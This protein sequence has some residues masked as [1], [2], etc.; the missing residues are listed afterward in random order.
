MLSASISL[1][2][3][4]MPPHLPGVNVTH[5]VCGTFSVMLAETAKNANAGWPV[6]K[7]GSLTLLALSG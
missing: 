5:S 3:R 2:M 4:T 7:R 1:G 6:F